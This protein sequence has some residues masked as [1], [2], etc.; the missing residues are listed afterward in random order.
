MTDPVMEKVRGDGADINVAVWEG[1]GK[2]ILCVHGIT[3]NCRSWDQMASTLTPRHKLIAMDLRG[4]GQSDK[5]PSGYSI[6]HHIRDI[7]GLLDRMGLDKVVLM[8][9]SLGAFISLAY[10]AECPER[11]DRIILVDG[12]GDLSEEQ[13]NN[14]FEG[15]RPSLER[16]GVVYPS[17]DEYLAKMKQAPYIQPWSPVWET[18]Y[19][20]EIMDVEGGI[21]ANIDP[22][23]IQEEALN[24][25]QLKTAELYPR[26]SANLLILRATDG[27]FTPDDILL[28]EDALEKML[29][30]IPAARHVDVT[31]TNH[32]TIV[33]QPNEKR[34]QAIF[35]FLE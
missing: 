4:R 31:G 21:S 8:G 30:E 19:R 18:Y 17:A 33:F 20:Y 16:L 34:D 6:D 7:T 32:Y 23:H 5:P 11:V 3:A 24:V 26:V 2:T 13:M 25:R 15:I 14:V 27:L 29:R 1:E 22:L 35:T 28:P 10:G 12:G 9:H